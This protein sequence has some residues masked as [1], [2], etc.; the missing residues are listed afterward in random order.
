MIHHID[1][2]L[3]AWG[4]WS[5]RRLERDFSGNP[6]QFRYREELPGGIGLRAH[7]IPVIEAQALETEMAVAGL[8]RERPEQGETICAFYR[9]C[10]TMPAEYLADT[11]RCAKRT[12][13][14]RI[15]QAHLWIDAWLELRARGVTPQLNSVRARVQVHA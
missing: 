4:Q 8:C 1:A 6:S 12:L 15:D 7:A 10:P 2:R 13:Y 11:L 14:W 5:A 9:D 3:A